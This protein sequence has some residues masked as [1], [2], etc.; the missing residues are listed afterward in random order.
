MPQHGGYT[1]M[2][3]LRKLCANKKSV[4]P[5]ATIVFKNTV[6]DLIGCCA[7]SDTFEHWTLFIYE[8]LYVYP[9]IHGK[10]ERWYDVLGM[11]VLLA[12]A[13]HA[14]PMYL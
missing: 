2:A 14:P 8:A 4:L 11:G 1:T 12:A 3:L 13:D 6:S 9:Q 5:L 10:A 7:S